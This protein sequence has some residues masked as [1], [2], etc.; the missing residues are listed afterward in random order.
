MFEGTESQGRPLPAR[1]TCDVAIVGY[2][3]VGMV[4]AALLAQRGL[5]VVVVERWPARYPLSRAGHC[6]SET[7]RT[8]QMLGIAEDVELVVRPMLEWSLVDAQ[9]DV[10]ATITLG[11]GGGGWKDSYLSHQPEIEEIFDRRAHELGARVFMGTAADRI[12]NRPDGV[13]LTV[14]PS[15]APAD[16]EPR[17]EHVIEASYLIGADGARSVVRSAIGVERLDLGF[18]SLDQLVLDFEHH[19][20]DVD[21]PQLP[22]VYQVLDVERPLLAGRWSGSRHTRFEFAAKEGE[23]REYLEDEGTCWGFLS[24]WGITPADGRIDRRAVYTFESRLAERWREGRVLLVGD[25]AHT[26]PP[27]MGQGMCS[28]MRDA[29]NLSWKLAAVLAG[30]ADETL[31]DTYQSER[32]PHA[33]GVVEMSMAT[34]SMILERDPEAGRRRDEMLRS[35]AVPPAPVFPRLGEGVVAT[36]AD[37]D[38][39]GPVGRPAPQARIA[40]GRRVDRLD[41]FHAPGWKIVSRHAVPDGLFDQRQHDLVA[42]LGLEVLHV[43]RGPGPGYYVDIDGEYDLWFRAHGCKAFV[44]RPDNYV[45]GTAT[46]IGDLPALLDELADAL[47]THGWHGAATPAPT[48]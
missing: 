19:D 47:A 22:E 35:G 18:R 43:S 13:T 17:E 7:M 8:Y 29:V 9:M 42:R 40:Q 38:V 39:E 10:L 45:F 4:T 46:T 20:H 15:E 2:G 28:G 3:P 5:D 14:S 12:E 6:D 16:G 44:S 23:S 1:T 26:M 25:A 24:R 36:L 11:Q 21:L 31:L 41:E 34:G 33:R 32:E 37:G 30:E 27:F 48:S